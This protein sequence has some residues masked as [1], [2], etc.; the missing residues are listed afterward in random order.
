M[1]PHECAN[2]S[3]SRARSRRSKAARRE[4]ECIRL[5]MNVRA[6]GERHVGMAQPGRHQRDGHALQMHEGG[7]GMPGVVQPYLRHVRFL[8]AAC[9][10]VDS[11]E[12]WYG[13]PASLQTT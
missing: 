2:G 12:G 11:V 7:A 6:K 3:F 9:H 13:S 1:S 10:M 8:M 4:S 5:G